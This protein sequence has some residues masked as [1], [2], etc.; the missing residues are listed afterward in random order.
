M[1]Y[2][3]EASFL[4]GNFL[5][6]INFQVTRS[7]F[8]VIVVKM[9]Y[10]TLKFSS[11]LEFKSGILCAWVMKREHD[12]WLFLTMD[13]FVSTKSGDLGQKSVSYFLLWTRLEALFNLTASFEK[14]EFLIGLWPKGMVTL[15]MNLKHSRWI[16]NR[17]PFWLD[18][19]PC[20][21]VF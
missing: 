1:G 18:W 13:T 14:Y 21:L 5:N 17:N 3:H 9:I 7:K 15:T 19:P 16:W 4:I 8:K 12:W 2:V 20:D 10:V 6:Y 11:K